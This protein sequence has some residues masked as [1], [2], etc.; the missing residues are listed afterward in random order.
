MAT[1]V[2]PRRGGI[3]GGE[4]FQAAM[5]R[6]AAQLESAQDARATLDQ[7]DQEWRET[8]GVLKDLPEKVMHPIMVPFGPLA[9]FPGHIE[10]T[11]EVM[12]QLSSEYFALRTVHHATEM[13]HR[14]MAHLRREKDELAKKIREIEMMSGLAVGEDAVVSDR[15]ATIRRDEDGCMAIREPCDENG[16]TLPLTSASRPGG[17]GEAASVRRDA[18]GF[19]DICEPCDEH[20]DPLAP[21]G[22]APVATRRPSAAPASRSDERRGAGGA[23]LLARLRELERLEED[24]ETALPGGGEGASAGGHGGGAAA[25]A[26]SPDTLARMRELERLEEMEELDNLCEGMESTGAAQ[27][28]AFVA[29]GGREALT[30]NSAGQVQSPADLFRQMR[31]IDEEV[32]NATAAPAAQGSFA[33]PGREAARRVEAPVAQS[34]DVRGDVRER[35]DVRTQVLAP[36]LAA[37]SSPPL[38]GARPGT[39]AGGGG[40]AE[41][42]APKRVSKFKSERARASGQ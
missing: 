1:S 8:L 39:A 17:P 40:G 2:K 5:H 36:S 15:G 29:G 9:F 30:A 32:A 37:L 13:G 28:E 35:L 10:H 41:E 7:R 3:L 33:P 20:G 34:A 38:G 21:A 25:A 12:C 42:E 11:N 31:R 18:D 26:S 19:L 4:A 27:G 22:A 24:G 16:E 6:M 23:D 14:R